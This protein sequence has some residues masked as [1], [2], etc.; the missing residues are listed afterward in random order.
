M[1]KKFNPWARNQARRALVQALYQ[2]QLSATELEIL[3]KEYTVGKKSRQFDSEFFLTILR[4]V[5]TNFV[6]IDG[7][8]SQHLDRNLGDLD[9][10][11]KAIL[12]LGSYELKERQD[13]PFRVVVD[14]YVELAK[15]FG[16]EDSFKYVN[17]ILDAVGRKLRL[18]G[19]GRL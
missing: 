4:A 2:W 3:E 18:S 19:D 9:P 15:V 5:L 16:A 12:R 10:I 7:I 6:E 1:Q 17:G 13:V 11:E 8:Y 14:E